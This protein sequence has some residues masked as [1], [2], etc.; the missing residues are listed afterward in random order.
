MFNNILLAIDLTEP[1]SWA[2]SL[3]VALELCRAWSARLHV[4]TVATEVNVQVAS[5]FPPDAN[6]RLRAQTAGELQAWVQKNMPAGVAAEAIVR[7][8][9]IHREILAAAEK[10]GADL[11]VMSSHKPAIRDV[12][13]GANAA[14]VVRHAACSVMV[15]RG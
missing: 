6:E 8:G 9:R 13:L 3:P 14:Q 11:I 10:A 1:S 7:Q 15:V 5:F 2:R 12:L 4:V